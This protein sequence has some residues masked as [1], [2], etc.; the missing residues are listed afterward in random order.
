VKDFR[1]IVV[2][3][4]LLIVCPLRPATAAEAPTIRLA[5]ICGGMTPMLAE[6]AIND[7][8]FERAHL[9]VE[10]YCFPGGAP[11][12]QALIGKSVDI[13]VGSYEHV[14]R[15]RA[16]GFDV[17]AYAEI[18]DGMSYVL[19]AKAGSPYRTL[20]DVKGQTLGIT[21]AGSLSET[22]L[23]TGLESVHLNPDRDVQIVSAGA[24][25]T[26]LAA[27]EAN[28]IAAG[29]ITEPASTALV[30]DGSYRILYDNETPFAGNVLMAR[31]A[32]VNAHRGAVRR[33]FAVLLAVDAKTRADPSSAIAPLRKDFFTVSPRIMLQAIQHQLMHVPK[34]LLVERRGTDTVQAIELQSGD[35]KMPIPFRIAVDSSIVAKTR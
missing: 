3:A 5:L 27:L 23:R 2:A 13:F 20:A 1:L 18:Y 11:A 22:A 6:I 31:A 32:W 17:K 10:K 29:M 12:V 21:A 30:A 35:I 4:A 33:L 19:V 7:G 25:S 15:Q 26:M 24:G 8:S 28:R 34:G 14:L 9:Q 16:R